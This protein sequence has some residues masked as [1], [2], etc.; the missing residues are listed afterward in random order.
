VNV[1]GLFLVLSGEHENLPYSEVKAILEAEGFQYRLLEKLDQVVRLDVDSTCVDALKRRAALTRVCGLELAT[2]EA[3]IN[4]I[5]EAVRSVDFSEVLTENDCFVVRVKHVKEYSAGINGMT[6]EGALGKLI[7]EA[8]PNSLVNLKKPSKTF[9][10]VLTGDKFVFGL[11]LADIPGKPFMERRPRKKPFFH[12]SAMPA[13]LA[14]CMVNLAKPK[15]GELLLDPFCGTGGMLIE[16][17]LIDCRILGLDV[18]RRMVKGSLRNM[19][20]FNIEAEGMLVADARS[21]PVTRVDCVVTDPPYGISATT[22]R[23]SMRQIVEEVLTSVHSMLSKQRRVC[24]A[25]PRTLNIAL[26][27]AELGYK[28]IESNLV[29]VHRSLTREIAVFET[30]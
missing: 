12:P 6:L 20:H 15:S 29:Y 25:A 5:T 13:K 3:E 28:H 2:S 21:P 4:R 8:A 19:R 27:G 17:G 16:A 9:L 23:R 22:L 24:L 30:V 10:G 7:R 1:A 14:R 26:I 18:Q 11:K